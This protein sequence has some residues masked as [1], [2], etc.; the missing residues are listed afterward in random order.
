ML[1]GTSPRYSRRNAVQLTAQPLFECNS[2]IFALQFVLAEVRR[3]VVNH[4]FKL[5][6]DVFM[7]EVP[8][9]LPWAVMLGVLST[10]LFNSVVDSVRRDT[11]VLPLAIQT[12]KKSVGADETGALASQLFGAD[13]P[14][15]V[16][17]T[18]WAGCWRYRLRGNFSD[19]PW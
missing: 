13:C 11:E 10:T 14:A 6:C 15:P 4:C 5:R 9:C 2:A 12:Q 8:E 3:N 17:V 16:E 18:S 19:I 1:V 7:F